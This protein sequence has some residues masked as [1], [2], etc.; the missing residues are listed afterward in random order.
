MK[1]ILEQL[2]KLGSSNLGKPV[3][4]K[5]I[6]LCQKELTQNHNAMVPDSFLELLHLYNAINYDGAN[7]FGISPEGKVFLD[8]V[9]ANKMSRF[10]GKPQMV[11]LGCDEFDYIAYNAQKSLYQI[12]D[13]EDMEV[14]EEYSD[15]EQALRHILKI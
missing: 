9:I 13:K 5:K 12:I 6:I 3:N 1:R 15:I 8:L 14:L 4:I 10:S 7:I 2:Q 11:I